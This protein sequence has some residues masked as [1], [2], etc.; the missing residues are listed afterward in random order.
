MSFLYDKRTKKAIKWIWVVLALLIALSM[1]FAY[2]GGLGV[3]KNEP[4]GSFLKW[5]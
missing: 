5:R 4:Y 1:I 2:S 3:F